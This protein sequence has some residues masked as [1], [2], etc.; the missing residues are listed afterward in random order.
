MFQKDTS[1]VFMKEQDVYLF[2]NSL[3]KAEHTMFLIVYS[4]KNLQ[5]INSQ[6]KTLQTYLI[7]VNTSEL[8]YLFA[9]APF[10]QNVFT[11]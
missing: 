9:W 11:M 6:Q 8:Q 3:P 1:P 5:L 2:S 4:E 10:C 7:L